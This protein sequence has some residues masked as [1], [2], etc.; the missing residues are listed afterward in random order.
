MENI[1]DPNKFTGNKLRLWNSF[2]REDA[3]DKNDDDQSESGEIIFFLFE[4]IL[5]DMSNCLTSIAYI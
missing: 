4:T 2:D 5:L 3:G 1:L